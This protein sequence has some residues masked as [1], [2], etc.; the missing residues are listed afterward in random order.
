MLQVEAREE[1]RLRRTESYAAGRRDE[2]QRRD[3]AFN[4]GRRE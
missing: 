2:L 1:R 4:E 3:A